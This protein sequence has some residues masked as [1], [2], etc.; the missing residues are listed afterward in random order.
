MKSIR[1]IAFSA[2]LAVGAFTTITYTSCNTDEC[3]D[4]ECF[5]GGTC[6]AG[7]CACPT[8]YEGTDCTTLTRDKF[9][10]VYNGNETCTI[11]SDTYAITLSANSEDL[12][13]NYT[14]VYNQNLSAVCTITSTNTFTFSGSAAGGITY[15][16]TGS[17]NA[18]TITVDYTVN[19]GVSTNSCKFIGTK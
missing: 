1:N 18:N 4:V 8:G 9:V 16:G 7:S 13:I 12:K 10:G 5:N 2:L 14:N 3:E 15:N 11:G 19:D 17:L 6:I